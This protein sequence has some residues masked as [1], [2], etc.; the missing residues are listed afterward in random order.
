MIKIGITGQSGFIGTHLYNYI[1]L[2][3]NIKR[4]EFRDEFFQEES[5]LDAF[6]SECEV[7]VHL[8]ALNRHPDPVVIY[9]TNVDLVKQLIASCERTGSHPHIIHASSTQEDTGTVYG[10]SKK[11]GRKRFSDWANRHNGTY[12]GLIIPNVFG[13]FCKPNYN[14]FVATFAYKLIQEEIPEI[15]ID[16]TV[17]LIYV[18]DLVL[19]ILEIIN[20]GTYEEI[21]IP[22][23]GKIKVSE[24]LDKFKVYKDHYMVKEIFP[25]IGSYFDQCLFNTFRSYI[26]PEFFP[27]YF[28]LHSDARGSFAEIV[29]T[30][31]QG[32]FS[33]ST[34]K[35]GITRGNHFHIRKIERFAV[36]KGVALI[37]TRCIGKE[38]IFEYKLNG[39]KPGY[40]D[41]PVWYTHNIKNIGKDELITLFW[42]NEFYVPEDTDTYNEIV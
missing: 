35:P 27:R 12:S 17:E 10:E 39:D 13:P 31:G 26:P 28:K 18:Q 37:Q 14:S 30:Y 23:T 40:V 20:N 22:G 34:T 42:I 38:E 4:V 2:Q 29:K 33:F 32:Q 19:K 11:E 25:E 16:A 21:R 36:L 3:K 5:L 15:H 24:L 7:I 6:V 1:G 9:N 41:M 8:A